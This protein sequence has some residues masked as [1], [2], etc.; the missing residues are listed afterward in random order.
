MLELLPKITTLLL[1]SGRGETKV[2]CQGHDSAKS[3]IRRAR[4]ES[5]ESR[6]K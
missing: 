2:A 4:C 3:K 5:N 6:M 1:K